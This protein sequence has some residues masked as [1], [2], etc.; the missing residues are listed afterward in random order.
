MKQYQSLGGIIGAAIILMQAPVQAAS[1]TQVTG[2]RINPTSNGI[3]LFLDT[4][5]MGRPAVFTV[6]QGNSFV[7]TI[8]NTQLQVDGGAFRQDNPAPGIASVVVTQLDP[9]SIRVIVSGT[10]SAPTGQIGDRN[11]QSIGFNVIAAP[12]TAPTLPAGPNAIAQEPATTSV[13][14]NVTPQSLNS[15]KSQTPDVLVP[16]PE[17]HGAR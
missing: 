10:T 8:I 15:G 14:P 1:V 7:A 5:N 3:N 16:H 9:H 6:T 4:D 17:R 12:G 11:S 2:V 13:S